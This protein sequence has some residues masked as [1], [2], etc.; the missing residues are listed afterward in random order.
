MSSNAVASLAAFAVLLAVLE[1]LR[2]GL[3]VASD[4][5]RKLFHMGVGLWALVAVSLF[6]DGVRAAIPFLV[7]GGVMYLSFRF[8]IFE[9]VEDDGASLGSVLLPL[10]CAML[11]LWFW[12]DR[13]YVA[14]A[15]IFAASFGDTTAALV[16]RRLGT[17]KYHTLGHP[18]SMEGT[19]SLFLA[20]GL[21]MAPVLAI[22]GGLDSHQAIAFAL[23]SA[24]VAAS[25]ETVSVYGTDN[26]TVPVATAATLATLVRFSQ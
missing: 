11:L 9:A 6:D 12:G 7:L 1:W 20:S 21:T 17:R 26:L 24:T 10:S 14:V 15:G 3:G 5:T 4:V 19:L 13:V 16:G 8:E 23:I 18:R 22:V 2:R 25:V